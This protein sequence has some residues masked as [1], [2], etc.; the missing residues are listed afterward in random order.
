VGDTLLVPLG[1]LAGVP[2]LLAVA[3]AGGM[4]LA[5]GEWLAAGVPEFV[6]L[7]L[8]AEL[9]LR[10]AVADGLAGGVPLGDS[11]GRGLA[12][13]VPLDDSLGGGVSLSDGVGLAPAL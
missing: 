1:E 5:V 2:L 6:P 7:A 3:L 8:G 12:G 10:D 9:P 11:L 4:A 13:G